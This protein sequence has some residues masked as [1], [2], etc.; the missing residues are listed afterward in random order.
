M[1]KQTIT[2]ADQE[3]ADRIATHHHFLKDIEIMIDW[4]RIN[5]I[6]EQVEIKRQSVAGRDAFSPEV[7][8]RIMLIKSWY[9]LSDY[10]MEEQLFYNTIFL[11][12][13]HLS[14]EN[15]I[16]DHSTICRLQQRFN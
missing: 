11:W 4:Q 13:C 9:G 10:Q 2:F 8:F 12:F 14:L 1:E 5:N 16:P 3:I 7:M 6:L 15:P